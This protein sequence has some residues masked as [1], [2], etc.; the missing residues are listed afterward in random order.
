[1]IHARRRWL[2]AVVANLW[3]YELRM[4]N[5]VKNWTP[6]FQN[7][8]KNIQQVLFLGPKWTQTPSIEIFR[9]LV[10]VIYSSFQAT[11]PHHKWSEISSVGVYL[12]MSSIK[13]NNVALVLYQKKG[14]FRQQF[15][16]NFDTQFYTLV[17]EELSL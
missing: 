10:Y 4:Y 17:Q 14:L 13:S 12:G 6:S 11:Q 1:M 5:N 9:F 15:H 2:N 3:P 16:V 8:D 7:P